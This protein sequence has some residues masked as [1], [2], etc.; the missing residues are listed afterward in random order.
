MKTRFGVVLKKI[1]ERVKS[2]S[3]ATF[4]IRNDHIEITTVAAHRTELGIKDPS[5]P[6]T[7]I[8][9][10][11]ADQRPLDECLALLADQSERN[12][13]FDPRVS[14]FTGTAVTACL[15]NTTLDSALFLLTDMADLSFVRI[16]N[17][18]YVTTSERARTM[19]ENWQRRRLPVTITGK[20]PK[21][22][23]TGK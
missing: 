1:L 10:L 17:S 22:A 18:Y 5:M 8:V 20:D 21:T 19:R 15:L 16:D 4:L 13:V 23:K 2:K 9:H 11:V 6:T 3:G 12:I 14:D 7:P